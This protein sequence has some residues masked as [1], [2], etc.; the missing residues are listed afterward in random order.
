MM[1]GVP[2]LTLR[3]LVSLLNRGIVVPTG[4]NVN[5]VIKGPHDHQLPQLRRG[6]QIRLMVSISHGRQHLGG[7][8][9]VS[10]SHGVTTS[11]AVGHVLETLAIFYIGPRRR[12][13]SGRQ[14]KADH[15]LLRLIIDLRRLLFRCLGKQPI[16]LLSRILKKASS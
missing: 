8:P 10:E 7:N 13:T 3:N 9:Q 12:L 16:R 4:P 15:A 2:S 14:S 6:D 1:L 11:L 5:L